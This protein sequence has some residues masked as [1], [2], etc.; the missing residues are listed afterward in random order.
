[1]PRYIC[2][3]GHFYQPPRENPWIET[4]ELQDSA[5]PYHDWNERIGAE[6]YGPNSTSRILDGAGRIAE[7]VN[8]YA[9]IS[10]NFGPTLLA[11][12]E[13]MMPTVYER[14]LLADQL[15]M[16]NFSGH[17]SAMAQVYNHAIMPLMNARDKRTQVLWGIKDFVRRF[18]RQPE[19]MWLAEAAVDL[20]TLELLAD[21]GIKFTVLA[22]RQA[23]RVRAKSGGDWMDVSGERIDPRIPYEQTLPSGHKIALFFYDG[24]ISRA[25]AFEGLLSRGENL[26]DRLLGAFRPADEGPQLV[27]IAT[28]GETF[29]H[30]HR[31]GEMALSY[32]LHHIESNNLAHITNYGEFLELFPPTHEV[33]IFENS[34]W[35]CVHG[36]ERW[37]S[38][39]GC[40]SG[41][42]LGWNQEW[43]APLKQ[44]LDWLRDALAPQF[45]KDM[46]KLL[47]DPWAARN[48]YIDVIH[49][50]APLNVQIFLERHRRR[51]LTDPEII[52]VLKAME[53]QRHA[54]LMFTSCGWFFDEISGIET[55]QVIQYAARAI[56]L[57][58]EIWGM[59]L[60]EEFKSRLE[61]AKSNIPAHQNGR[62][63]YDHFVKPAMVDL[64]KVAAH[65]AVSSLFEPYPDK[66]LI[67]CFTVERQDY[68]LRTVG[69]NR[70]LV[71][72][73]RIVSEITWDAQDLS[74]G[75][76][77]LGDHSLSGGVR[78]YGGE[79]SYQGLIKEG[80]AAF[81]NGDLPE[82]VRFLDRNFQSSVYSLRSLFKDEQR[83]ILG[84]ILQTTLANAAAAYRQI[85][86]QNVQLMHFLAS[87]N[88]PLPEAFSKAAEFSLA[89]SLREV[90][91]AEVPDLE[92]ARTL[93]D[94]ASLGAVTLS[95]QTL[96]FPVRKRLERLAINFQENPADLEPLERLDQTVE[97][98][99][100]MPFEI[101]L[102]KIQNIYFVMLQDVYPKFLN[103][104]QTDGDHARRWVQLFRNLGDRLGMRL[105]ELTPDVIEE[106]QCVQ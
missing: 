12:M 22:P 52:R 51:D 40:N 8:N 90:F 9:K 24:P 91:L 94:E 70:M 85:Y 55:V 38:N 43:R 71:G 92:R 66:T 44:A 16:E 83:K 26:A 48:E 35:S 69:R 65:Y 87:H 57:A 18:K 29:G 33:E 15:S 49:D 50:R 45:E 80:N 27:H 10:F 102:R 63:I 61:K 84:E 21:N 7:I 105:P 106:L 76:L 86:E 1:M 28:D 14:V 2:I 96:E 88:M 68:Q 81:E 58:L 95:A 82:V 100:T 60:E 31:L 25:V 13:S 4:I 104:F 42:H 32:A 67:F 53:L 39:C 56:Q 74:F 59:D 37:R 19:G 103:L 72:R 62:W 6:C 54:L 34:S 99:L 23:S 46:K 89:D 30:H 41:M 98:A 11:W 77:H 5:H 75:V 17:G 97:V 79:E 93:L 64:S 101:N 20:E 36:V 3:H 47:K 78:P 73:A